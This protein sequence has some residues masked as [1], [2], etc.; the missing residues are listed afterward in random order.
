MMNQCGICGGGVRLYSDTLHGRPI[1][2]WKHTWAPPG[3]EPHRPVLGT[4]VDEVTLDR[5]RKLATERHDKKVAVRVV[6]PPMPPPAVRLMETAVDYGWGVRGDPTYYVSGERVEVVVL[7]LRR[8]DL[9]ALG[10]WERKPGKNWTYGFGLTLARGHTKQ[11]GSN[12]LTSWVKQ[13]DERC[14]TCGRSS[15]THNDEE[16]DA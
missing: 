6:E 5:L 10:V 1:T 2:D 16:C 12:S 9:G 3:T 14:D 11:V 13:R 15:L 7:R 4:P 8:A